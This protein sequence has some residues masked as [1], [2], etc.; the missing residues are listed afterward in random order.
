[1]QVFL[2]SRPVERLMLLLLTLLASP[3][4]SMSTTQAHGESWQSWRIL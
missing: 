3:L 2:Q 4:L 1:M